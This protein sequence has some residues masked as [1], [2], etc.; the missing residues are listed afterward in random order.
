MTEEAFALLA[1]QGCHAASLRLTHEPVPAG[2]IVA[3]EATVGTAA[4]GQ[5]GDHV[6]GVWEI[7]PSISTDVEVEE[8]FIVLHGEATVSFADGSPD[9]HLRPGVVGRLSAGARTTWT[10]QQTLRKIYLA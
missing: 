3:G 7:T 8:F 10:V 2:R 6:I 1:N 9:M 5:L 4:L